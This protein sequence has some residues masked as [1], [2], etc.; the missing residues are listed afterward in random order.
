[1]CSK[2]HIFAFF[3][4]N[5]ACFIYCLYMRCVFLHRIIDDSVVAEFEHVEVTCSNSSLVKQLKSG[6]AAPQ[7]L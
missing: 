1:M 2:K 5:K 3:V 7:D 4:D 6:K